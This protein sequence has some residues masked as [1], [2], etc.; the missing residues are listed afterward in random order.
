MPA[1]SA[2]LDCL[3]VPALGTAMVVLLAV[4]NLVESVVGKA[5]RRHTHHRQPGPS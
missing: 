3:W 2:L 1:A 5:V 4:S